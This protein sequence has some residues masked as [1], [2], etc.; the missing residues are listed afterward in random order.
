[1]DT[2]GNKMQIT[3]NKASKAI[4]A[5][6]FSG[7]ANLGPAHSASNVAAIPAQRRLSVSSTGYLFQNMPNAAASAT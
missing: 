5:R 1:M 4:P 3:H 6:Y 7:R 2:M